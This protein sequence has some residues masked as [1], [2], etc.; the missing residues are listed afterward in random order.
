MKRGWPFGPTLRASLLSSA[1]RRRARSCSSNDTGLAS[2]LR[3]AAASSVNEAYLDLWDF[4]GL[5]KLGSIIF[6][7]YVF[8]VRVVLVAEVRELGENAGCV[9]FCDD[10]AEAAA[11]R[12]DRNI[13]RG[14]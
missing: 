2:A 10:V 14:G 8:E 3:K 12:M 13:S 9:L 5:D 4:L 1:E 11:L 6:E 7:E